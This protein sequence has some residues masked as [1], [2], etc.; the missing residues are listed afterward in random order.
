MKDQISVFYFTLFNIMLFST[1][2]FI[3][4]EQI[5]STPLLSSMVYGHAETAEFLL[6]KGAKIENT[7]WVSNM[8]LG[9]YVITV[10]SQRL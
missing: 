1:P 6:D 5:G 8:M 7:D 10:V 9:E 2:I 4:N 3:M